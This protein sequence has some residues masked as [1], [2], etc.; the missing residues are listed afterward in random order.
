MGYSYFIMCWFLLYNKVRFVVCLCIQMSSPNWTSHPFHLS[1]SPQSTRWAPCAIY[2]RFPPAVCFTHG[3]VYFMAVISTEKSGPDQPW[4]EKWQ[5]M[6]GFLPGK[7]HGQRSL[8]G[9]SPWGHKES[10]M[11]ERQHSVYMSIPVFQFPHPHLPAS[12]PHVHSLHLCLYSCPADRLIFTMFLTPYICISRW[13]LFFSFW[14]T[15][16]CMIDSMSI[17]VSTND[18]VLFLF[19][20]K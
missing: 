6:P 5:P 3:S 19:M 15:S 8:A 2:R 7:L 20:A 17:H 18:S 16:L 13:Y 10:G 4:S 12:C 1:R 14:F 9:C 11:T